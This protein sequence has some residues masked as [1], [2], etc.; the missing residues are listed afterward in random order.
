GPGVVR[1]LA[2]TVRDI[3]RHTDPAV[4]T[5]VWPWAPRAIGSNSA[6]RTR[7]STGSSA[8][9]ANDSDAHA[10]TVDVDHGAVD[11]RGFVAG[12]VADLRAELARCARVDLAQP[13]ASGS[14]AGGSSG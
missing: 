2:P 12:E 11:E 8:A 10:T 5:R 9:L 3:Q 14:S 6:W 13:S 7:R 1:C 4:H